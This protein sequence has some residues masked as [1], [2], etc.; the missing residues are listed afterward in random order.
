VRRAPPV[1]TADLTRLL[2]CW[3]THRGLLPEAGTLNTARRH[4]LAT[5]VHDCGDVP[6]AVQLL[7]D[8]TCE[9][10]QDEFWAQKRFGLDTLLPKALGRAEAWRS[11]ITPQPPISSPSPCPFSVGQRVWY[12]RE[13]YNI[14]AITGRYI[15]LYDDFNGSARI[16]RASD[17]IRALRTVEVGA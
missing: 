16:L 13:Q 10:A 1:A 9:V 4:A 12:R 11:R 5:L 17:D 2:V 3:N 15:D 14:E 7:A 8:A 6:T